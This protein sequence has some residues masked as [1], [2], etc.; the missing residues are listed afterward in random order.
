MKIALTLH[1]TKENAAVWGAKIA[2]LLLENGAEVFVTAEYESLCPG[3]Q[4]AEGHAALM[5]AADAVIAVGGDGTIIHTAKHA[6]EA[7]VPILGVNLGRFG[8]LAGIEKEEYRKTLRILSGNCTESRRMML[9]ISVRGEEGV[10]RYHALNDAVLSGTLAKLFDYG[11]SVDGSQLF[12]FRADGLI[13]ATPTG[14][15]AYSLSSGGPVLDPDLQCILLT[16]I[17]PHLLFNRSTVFGG[18]REIVL[19][20]LGGAGDTYLTVD[21]DAPIRIGPHDTV[22]VK[23]S[24]LVTRL[25]ELD[26]RVFYD[27]VDRKIMHGLA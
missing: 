8:F 3:V 23:R 13:C 14:S 7:D 25:I 19:T 4:T 11:L 24:A 10:R 12:R 1:P 20:P 9:D 18:D 6:C 26:D 27:R 5:Q 21:G 2:E 17:C 22:S 15:T 16:P